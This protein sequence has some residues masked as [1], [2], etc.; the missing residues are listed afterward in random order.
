[1]FPSLIAIGL[2]GGG[3]W[4]GVSWWRGSQVKSTIITAAVERGDLP[5]TVVERGELDSSKLVEVRCEVEGKETKLVTILPEGTP[6][7]KDQE[8]GRYDTDGIMK[9]FAEQEIKFK[10][11]DGEARA[12]KAELEVQENKLKSEVAK[13][14]LAAQLAELDLKK[15]DKAEY[16]ADYYEK[17]GAIDLAKKELEEAKSNLAFTD[18]LVTRGL[19]QMEQRRLKEMEVN[20]KDYNVK[21]DEKKLAVLELDRE[22]KL[23]ELKFK[24]LDCKLE[25][26]R[27][28]KGMQAAVDKARSQ[29]EAA[30][31]TAKLEKKQLERFRDQLDRFV[32]K[33]PQ[34]GILVYFKRPWDDSSRI[35]PG[36]MLYFQ[37]PIYTLP[38]LAQMKV[39]VQVHESVIKKVQMGL[40]ATIVVEALSDKVLHGTVAKV[41][42]L[43]Q[44]EG[45]RTS[46]KQYM[47]EITIDDLPM[48]A[49]LK[50]GMTGEVKI[51][52][53]TLPNVLMVPVQAVTER[54]GKHYAYVVNRFGVE[55]REVTIGEANEQHVQIVDGLSEGDQVALDARVRAA[56]EAR[57]SEGE[58][59]RSE[60]NTQ[61]SKS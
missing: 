2:L 26:E 44:N 1:M 47:T 24:A 46:V 25:L 23:A 29:W 6:V 55:R 10:K 22:R 3:G 42:T 27:T 37:Q 56:A 52:I 59:K 9:L 51:M 17:Q 16:F 57:K 39:K 41:A 11:A 5:I 34:D 18:R 8:V 19:S 50:P 35:Q 43:A 12:A 4:Y 60:K 32:L 30:E 45:W 13:A 58:V 61:A 36:A 28:R 15:Y 40:K 31:D 38:D 48:G 20:Q 33:A 7:K 14:D 54:D 53:Q 21:R 49:G